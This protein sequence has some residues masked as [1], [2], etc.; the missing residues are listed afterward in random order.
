MD[1][2][3][4]ETHIARMGGQV[5]IVAPHGQQTTLRLDAEGYLE[6]LEGPLGD[7]VQVSHNDR[8]LLES[9]ALAG[10]SSEAYQLEYDPLG[11]V[12]RT[13]DPLGYEF[14]LESTTTDDGLDQVRFTDAMD[15]VSVHG[16]TSLEEGGS[17]YV[18][19]Q[20]E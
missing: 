5:T 7:M 11:R 8:G 10:D 14:Q 13:E 1:R 2:S 19:G 17:R 4:L 9:I 3:G 6:E 20:G 16:A 15:R 18:E 12:V